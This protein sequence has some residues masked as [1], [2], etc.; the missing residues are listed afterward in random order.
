[1]NN[2]VT[3][4]FLDTF[5]ETG[6][7]TGALDYN[8]VSGFSPP[9]ANT[10]RM[11]TTEANVLPETCMMPSIFERRNSIQTPVGPLNADFANGHQNRQ[12]SSS[13]VASAEDAPNAFYEYDEYAFNV[14]H[15]VTPGFAAERFWRGR[16]RRM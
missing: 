3:D 5:S 2:H 7:S 11:A 10:S 15:F 4:D 14:G 13:D 16:N 12:F 1:M 8:E 9:E 6:F